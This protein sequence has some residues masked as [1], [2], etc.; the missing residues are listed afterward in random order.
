M[1]TLIF[2]W[3][4]IAPTCGPDPVH[5]PHAVAR[6]GA[7]L[8]WKSCNLRGPCAAAPLHLLLTLY[9]CSDH[10]SVSAAGVAW[11]FKGVRVEH[12]CEGMCDDGPSRQ[13][14]RK[15]RST[16]ARVCEQ[17]SVDKLASIHRKDK[18]N[19]GQS[20]KAYNKWPRIRR[21]CAGLLQGVDCCFQPSLAVNVSSPQLH[22]ATRRHLPRVS[23]ACCSS[24]GGY[25]LNSSRGQHGCRLS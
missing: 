20:C 8:I 1:H 15:Q 24:Y 10:L 9:C 14:C 13:C 23:Q 21:T 2:Q 11:P 25:C 6:P 16:C 12:L 7:T 22:P 3:H 18:H 4:F 17:P 19:I 5:A